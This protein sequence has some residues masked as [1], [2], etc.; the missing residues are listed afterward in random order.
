MTMADVMMAYS[1]QKMREKQP[2]T[3]HK[4]GIRGCSAKTTRRGKERY[5]AQLAIYW[6]EKGRGFCF[7][8]HPEQPAQVRRGV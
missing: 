2:M 7:Y 3:E 5:C 6:D 1:E 8:H 4:T